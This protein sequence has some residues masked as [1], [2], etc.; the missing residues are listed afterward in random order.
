MPAEIQA[1]EIRWKKRL[2]IDFG[3]AGVE[4]GLIDADFNGDGKLDIATSS[5]VIVSVDHRDGAA[6]C[7]PRRFVAAHEGNWARRLNDRDRI[8][9][10]RHPLVTCLGARPL[11]S[12][13]GWST[14]RCAAA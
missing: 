2:Q 3:F 9:A 7:G 5:S 1:S 4:G 11:T 13:R 10:R 12:S 6:P 14:R 8:A